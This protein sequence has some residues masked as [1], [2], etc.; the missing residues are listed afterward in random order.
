MSTV[1]GAVVVMMR[2]ETLRD[3]HLYGLAQ[4]FVAVVTEQQL[5]LRVDQNNPA[6]R[7]YNDHG[8]RRRVQKPTKQFFCTLAIGDVTNYS[9]HEHPVGGLDGAKTDLEREFG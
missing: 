4:Q 7:I 6:R 8:I 3:K 9:A 1:G 5:R 2:P